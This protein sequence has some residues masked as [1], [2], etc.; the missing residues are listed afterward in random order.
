MVVDQGILVGGGGD[1]GSGYPCGGGGDVKG[2]GWLGLTARYKRP[3]FYAVNVLY[4]I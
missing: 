3:S 2:V 1:C 4:V